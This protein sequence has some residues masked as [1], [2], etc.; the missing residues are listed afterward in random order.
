M[1]CCIRFLS[2]SLRLVSC[3]PEAW[4]GWCWDPTCIAKVSQSSGACCRISHVQRSQPRAGRMVGKSPPSPRQAQGIAANLSRTPCLAGWEGDWLFP[5]E[6]CSAPWVMLSTW[7]SVPCLHVPILLVDVSVEGEAVIPHHPPVRDGK[8][9]Q[10]AFKANP[11][12]FA[13]SRQALMAPSQHPGHHDTLTERFIFFQPILGHILSPYPLAQ[14]SKPPCEQ[15]CSGG[16]GIKGIAMGSARRPCNE[17]NK[18]C[19]LHPQVLG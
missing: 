16:A 9:R 3:I 7:G 1:Q 10:G 19:F 13:P 6:P 15:Q 14:T 17:S 2:Q 11:T 5:W 8:L 12:H 4:G 18:G